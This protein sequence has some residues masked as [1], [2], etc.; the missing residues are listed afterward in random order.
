MIDFSFERMKRV[1]E[2]HALWWEHRLNRP[3][4]CVTVRDVRKPEKP[5][6][7]RVLG[8]ANCHDFSI[9]AK[10]VIADLDT[11]LSTRAYLG[12]AYPYV[13]FDAFGPGSLAAFLGAKVDNRTGGVWFFPQEKQE[14]A[15]IHLH[16]DPENVWVKRIK[17]IYR[18]GLERWGTLV[19]LGL[20]DLG[21]VMDVVATFVG[22]EE[23]LMALIDEPEE[24]MRLVGEAESA[25]VTAYND[26]A[27]VLAPQGGVTD[28]WGLWNRESGY[29]L[30]CDFSYMIGNPMFREFVLPTL[31]RDT[32]RL[33]NTIYHLDGKGELKHLD[34]LLAL[35]NLN[36]IQWVPGDG[37]P[38]G[39][40]WKEVYEKVIAAGKG[41]SVVGN[42]QEV[43]EVVKAL[44]D[45]LHFN[46]SLP[47]SQK[48]VAQELL[49]IR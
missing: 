31:N 27:S 10:D 30:Q 36:A 45:N 33:N 8:Q 13:N 25:W 20:P 5:Y 44:H 34:T 47:T 49:N 7:H 28:W 21:G 22:T 26:F 15:D 12:D 6:L 19:K 23:L 38:T 1:E 37:T 35:P 46:F 48:N 9:P 4:A 16:Y 17:D 41:A 14:I 29:I 3:L 32:G 11:A 39:I 2:N 24:V 40:V 42:P 43:A 18:A